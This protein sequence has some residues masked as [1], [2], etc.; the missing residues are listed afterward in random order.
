MV[1][2]QGGKQR[3]NFIKN[4]RRLIVAENQQVVQALGGLEVVSRVEKLCH[5]RNLK[6]GTQKLIIIFRKDIYPSMYFARNTILLLTT[7]TNKLRGYNLP[8]EFFQLRHLLKHIVFENIF[9]FTSKDFKTLI[10]STHTLSNLESVTIR[11]NT[12]GVIRLSHACFDENGAVVE[13]HPNLKKISI[14]P[15]IRPSKK[16]FTSMEEFV[17]FNENIIEMK[18][19]DYS[20][21][22]E[23]Y[24]KPVINEIIQNTVDILAVNT[25]TSLSSSKPILWGDFFGKMIS[26]RNNIFDSNEPPGSVSTAGEGV[27][28]TGLFQTL[29]NNMDLYLPY[30]LSQNEVKDNRE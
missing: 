5:F 29:R 21:Y 10:Q 16:E 17:K 3:R 30:L 26:K 11:G 7:D 20:Y 8:P 12:C 24:N 9:S 22:Q 4:S 19:I 6:K 14:H 1:K 13:I 23:F 2:H 18:V 28:A 27:V 25:A 15:G